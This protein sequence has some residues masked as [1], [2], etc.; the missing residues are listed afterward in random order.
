[1]LPERVKNII[2]NLLDVTNNGTI[3]W[4]YN[5]DLS[6]VYGTHDGS[7][8][9]ISFHFN[10]NFEENQFN[11]KITKNNKDYFFSSRETEDGFEELKNLYD[12]AQASDL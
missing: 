3:Q 1:M 11:I 7:D 6:T 10:P 9:E 8:Y 12:S 4:V 2:I 5:D